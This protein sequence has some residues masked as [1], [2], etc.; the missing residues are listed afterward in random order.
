[1]DVVRW[2]QTISENVAEHPPAGDLTMDSV[3]PN[4]KGVPELVK[5]YRGAFD[6]CRRPW[7]FR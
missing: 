4:D 5:A 6:G 1:M 7:P 2:D 3:H